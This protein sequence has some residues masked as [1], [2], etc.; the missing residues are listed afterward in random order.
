MG[1]IT[2]AL[3]EGQSLPPGPFML[4]SSCRPSTSAKRRAQRRAFVDLLVEEPAKA[5]AIVDPRVLREGL[6]PEAHWFW[7]LRDGSRSTQSRSDVHGVLV[8]HSLWLLQH[9]EGIPHGRVNDRTCG[10]ESC[11]RPSHGE[12]TRKRENFGSG[13]V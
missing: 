11:V 6:R 4:A 2:I 5:A 7:R 13:S 9:P 10:D 12:W 8:T 1:K 3:E